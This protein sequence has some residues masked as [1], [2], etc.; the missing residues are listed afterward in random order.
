MDIV[1]SKFPDQ[2]VNADTIKARLHK[3]AL[4]ELEFVYSKGITNYTEVLEKENGQGTV[5]LVENKMS[6]TVPSAEIFLQVRVREVFLRLSEKLRTIEAF[7]V[8]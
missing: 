1:H 8:S 6:H 4:A 5:V 2:Q 7:C 3:F